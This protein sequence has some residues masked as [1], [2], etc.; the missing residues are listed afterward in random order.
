MF[1]NPGLRKSKKHNTFRL[2]SKTLSAI[3]SYMSRSKQIPFDKKAFRNELRFGGALMKKTKGRLG[4]R[5]VSTRAP[6]HLVLRSSK[7]KGRFGFGYQSN[8]KKVNEIVRKTCAKYGVKLIEYSNNYNHLHLLVKFP[9]RAV[10]L[11]FIRSLTGHLALAVTGANRTRAL[12]DIFA[13]PASSKETKNPRSKKQTDQI[14]NPGSTKGF[15]DYRPFTRVVRSWRGYRIVRDYV[16]L[17]QLEAFEI[18]P[19]RSGRLRD[20]EP[21][22]HHYFRRSG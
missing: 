4:H 10:Y 14:D 20:V 9:S 5:P 1:K 21:G 11:R 8:L 16:I 6:M 19:K 3:P 12:R 13:V 2:N 17:N 18:I 22:E 15:W 7:A